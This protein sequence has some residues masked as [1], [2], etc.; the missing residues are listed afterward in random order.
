M[1]YTFLSKYLRSF[2]MY[3]SLQYTFLLRC[4]QQQ[5]FSSVNLLLNTFQGTGLILPN[6]KSSIYPL[7]FLIFLQLPYK[8]KLLWKLS[9][10][11]FIIFLFDN[12]SSRTSKTSSKII[13]RQHLNQLQLPFF[14]STST[15]LSRYSTNFRSIPQLHTEVLNQTVVSNPHK[16]V[17]EAHRS[18][19]ERISTL[20]TRR[21]SK[22]L[23]V[24]AV[25]VANPQK[26]PQTLVPQY[27]D[28]QKK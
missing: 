28:P 24:A 17:E 20:L 13:L 5:T 25:T 19:T 12:S 6:N 4:A 23:S 16:S 14:S 27:L 22:S 8:I 15:F 7:N 11:P 21:A 3:L 18:S 26:N 2:S 1:T 10:Y 9:K